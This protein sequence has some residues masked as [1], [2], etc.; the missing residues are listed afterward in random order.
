MLV[1]VTTLTRVS[2]QVPALKLFDLAAQVWTPRF[3]TSSQRFA[4]LRTSRST[5][6]ISVVQTNEEISMMDG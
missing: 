1:T 5:R 2:R 4:T 3:V 6:F